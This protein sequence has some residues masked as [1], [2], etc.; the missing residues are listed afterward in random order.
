MGARANE[1]IV[2]AIQCLSGIQSGLAHR[3][4]ANGTL[5][6]K[7]FGQHL[8]QFRD[9]ER[10]QHP[11]PSARVRIH[12]D[13]QLT[14]K[15]L[16]HVGHQAVLAQNHNGFFRAED[17]VRNI[18]AVNH[19]KP[20]NLRKNSFCMAHGGLVRPILNLVVGKI[21]SH[22][23]NIETRLIYSVETYGEL[24]QAG[25]PDYQDNL[26]FCCPVLYRNGSEHW[27]KRLNTNDRLT[28]F[29]YSFDEKY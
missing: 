18:G 26:V 28:Q 14:I 9:G 15:I 23:L 8:S 3:H 21:R 11:I 16:K 22:V 4:L 20:P 13:K 17:E 7:H 5:C 29:I 10:E 1:N 24:V 27:E 6:C 12:A 25:A 19:L 2:Y